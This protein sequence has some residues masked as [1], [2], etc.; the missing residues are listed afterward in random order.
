[1]GIR[2]L[3]SSSFGTARNLTVRFRFHCLATAINSTVSLCFAR[4]TPICLAFPRRRLHT[5]P[6]VAVVPL[7]RLHH[8]A[9]HLLELFKEA[10]GIVGAVLYAAQFLLPDACELGRFEQFF[11]DKPHQ[12]NAGRSGDEVLLLLAYVA[13]LEQCLDDGGAGG[14]AAY[15]VFLQGVAQLF[16]L[17]QL[18]CRLHGSKQGGFGVGTR[19]LGPL[20]YQA[21][22]VRTLF[23]TA[24]KGQQ[25][26]ALGGAGVL[27]IGFFMVS[28][29]G[30]SRCYGSTRSGCGRRG[31]GCG[32]RS[33]RRLVEDHT[34]ARLQHLAPRGLEEHTCRRAR[35][36]GSGVAAVG[37]ESGDEAARHHVE[38]TAL[39][40]GEALRSA[41]GGDDGVVV[42]DLGI[43]E[44][45]L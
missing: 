38:D 28:G 14:G 41:S 16:I 45:L 4:F 22:L 15:A 43:V 42:G 17:H 21:G 23:A 44:H 34:P 10:G 25:A 37:I 5:H 8:F 27:F 29:S 20:L 19:R 24:E 31:C 26:V 33:G 39:H 9:H 35:D 6:A 12:L 3:I 2:S 30:G 36:G 1:M 18:A 32:S 40:V 7:H 11:P 13:P